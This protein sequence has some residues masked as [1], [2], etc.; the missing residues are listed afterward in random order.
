MAP[1]PIYIDGTYLENNRNWHQ[2]D[3]Q[4]KADQIASILSRN[5]LRPQSVG[6]IG[7][8]AGAVLQCLGNSLGRDVAMRG[9]DISPHAIEIA[10]QKER[11]GLSYFLEDLLDAPLTT[12]FDVVMAIDV[13]EHVEDSFTFLRRL[14]TRGTYKVFHIPLELSAQA[15]LRSGRL[16]KSRTSVGHIHYYTKDLA[17]ATLTDTGYEVIDSS[18][19]C[20]GI[21]LPRR[22]WKANL[23]KLPR[24][25]LFGLSADFAARSIGGFS[26]LVLAR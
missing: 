19:T 25:L 26:L 1:S 7:C 10:Q 14:H 23:M 18:F 6:E 8:G 13:F 16:L 9:Y 12:S 2:A 4:W 3:S 22:G 5:G 24:K 21:E 17:L 11:P 20:G 15:V